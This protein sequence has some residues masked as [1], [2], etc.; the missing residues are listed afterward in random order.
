MGR[1]VNKRGLRGGRFV[2]RQ[3]GVTL[4]ETMMAAVIM[5]IGVVGV[6]SL[7]SVS[8]AQ[9]NSSGEVATRCTEFAQDKMEQL[10]ALPFTNNNADTTVYP[11]DFTNASGT[12]TGLG[13]AALTSA[14][15]VGGTTVG[16][17]V[18]GYVDYFDAYGAYLSRTSTG[19]YYTRQ[20]SISIDSSGKLKTIS[21]IVYAKTVGT[22]VTQTASTSVVCYKASLT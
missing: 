2:R 5:V 18:T 19:A 13:D 20:W 11:T 4:I 21:V 8:V 22:G 12:G 16:S 1:I 17:A 7:F 9:N 10:L 15:P 6:M 3:A 14:H